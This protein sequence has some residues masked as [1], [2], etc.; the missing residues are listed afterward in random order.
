MVRAE[1]TLTHHSDS[2]RT[3]PSFP[4]GLVEYCLPEEKPVCFCFKNVN[5][6]CYTAENMAA[7]KHRNV[8]YDYCTKRCNLH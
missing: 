4:P 5:D 7:I 2:A 1:H 6:N 3:E 8:S